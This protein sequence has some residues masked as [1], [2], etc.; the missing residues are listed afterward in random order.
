M[1]NKLIGVSLLSMGALTTYGTYLV[2][3]NIDLEA[4]ISTTDNSNENTF[5]EG[6]PSTITFNEIR[7]LFESVS[8]YDY[9]GQAKKPKLIEGAVLPDDI[10]LEYRLAGGV[11]PNWPFNA[12]TEKKAINVFRVDA[13]GGRTLLGVMNDKTIEINS[14]PFPVS[15]KN[16]IVISTSPI[17]FV[18]EVIGTIPQD[19]LEEGDIEYTVN[20]VPTPDNKAIITDFGQYSVHGQHA[21]STNYK[22]FDITSIL[23]VIHKLENVVITYDGIDHYNDPKVD[24]SKTPGVT[25]TKMEVRNSKGVLVTEMKN[26]DTYTIVTTYGYAGADPVTDTITYSIQK[27]SLP[28][29][30]FEESNTPYDG[31]PK[32]VKVKENVPE[33]VIVKYTYTYIKD[34]VVVPNPTE[35]GDY[36]ITVTIDAGPNYEYKGAIPTTTFT[37]EKA[38]LSGIFSDKTVLE[39]GLEHKLDFVGTLPAGVTLSYENNN[40]VEAGTY[41]VKANVDGGI[42]YENMHLEATLIINPRITSEPVVSDV[43]YCMGRDLVLNVKVSKVE[44]KLYYYDSSTSITPLV[45]VPTPTVV[46]EKTYYVAE[47]EF[48]NG[49]YFIGAKKVFK[50]TS[51]YCAFKSMINPNLSIENNT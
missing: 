13:S 1:K 32:L 22:E 33:G 28:P 6:T 12:S 11:I 7:V 34:G 19:I 29:F 14:I 39:D 31:T 43:T 20:D 44:L 42:N 50:I 38:K 46:E 25:I 5:Y 21:Q 3:D 24:L 47:G 45:E 51:S 48:L 26:A 41:L 18:Y 16:R 37:I 10:F 35:A 2:K 30:T 8:T 17:N 49:K 23:S 27:E 4:I 9:D 15:F 36:K 40:Q